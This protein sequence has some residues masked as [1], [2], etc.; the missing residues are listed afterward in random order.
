M[1]FRSES[2]RLSLQNDIVKHHQQLQTIRA[3]E[4]FEPDDVTVA[5]GDTKKAV[6]VESAVTVVNAM[7]QLYI[8]TTIA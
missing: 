5:K 4:N 2:G 7:S 6:V 1:L 3:I 8:T